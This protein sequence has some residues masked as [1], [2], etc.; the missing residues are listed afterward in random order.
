M[1]LSIFAADFVGLGNVTCLAELDSHL[2]CMNRRTLCNTKKMQFDGRHCVTAGRITT[3]TID[4]RGIE[5]DC[6]R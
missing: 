6:Q 2:I 3:S 1:K 4:I 5:P